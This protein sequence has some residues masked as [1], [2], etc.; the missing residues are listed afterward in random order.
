ML[1]RRIQS[2]VCSHI[3]T[4][5]KICSKTEELARNKLTA[6]G[7]AMCE[8]LGL[9][10]PIGS[11]WQSED[12]MRCSCSEVGLRCCSMYTTPQKFPPECVAVFDKENCRYVVHVKGNPRLTCP[13][14]A[15][16]G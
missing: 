7:M 2:R 8:R 5:K 9:R 10:Y 16:V 13:V 6:Q 11:I 3:G 15:G 4:K 12:C 1:C 14:F